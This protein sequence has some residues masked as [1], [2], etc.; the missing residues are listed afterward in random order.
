MSLVK[1]LSN[2]GGPLYSSLPQTESASSEEVV[3]DKNDIQLEDIENANKA[4]MDAKK[5]IQD[6]AV[7]DVEE[8]EDL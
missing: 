5:S 2:H 6:I 7:E 3:K 4:F 8:V 1:N